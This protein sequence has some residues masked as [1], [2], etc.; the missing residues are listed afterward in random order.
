MPGLSPLDD[1]DA[2]LPFGRA[3]EQPGEADELGGGIL[4]RD[5]HSLSAQH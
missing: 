2:R 1:S 5:A 3:A 4:A